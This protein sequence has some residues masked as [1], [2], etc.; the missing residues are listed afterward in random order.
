MVIYKAMNKE[1]QTK[2]AILEQKGWTLA[3]IGRALGLKSV[4]IESWKTG[5]R[6]PSSLQLVLTKLSELERKNRIPSKKVYAKGSRKFTPR[7]NA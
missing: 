7:E 6:S 4:T 3:N 5:G 1:V 2:I